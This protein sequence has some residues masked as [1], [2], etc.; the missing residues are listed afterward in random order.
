MP[1]LRLG[2]HPSNTS[3]FV[4]ERRPAPLDV[5]VTWVPTPGTATPAALRDDVIDLTGTGSTPPLT[6]LA[7]GADVV[8]LATSAPRPQHGSLVVRDDSPIRELADLAGRRV[9]LA[10]GSYQSSLLVEALDRE[11]LRWSD[12]DAVPGH[13]RAGAAAF[14][15]GE[16]D[17]WI[18]GDP[19]LADV[20]SRVLTRQ[21][22][23]TDELISNR[24]VWFARRDVV[25]GRREEVLAV[26]RA[27]HETDHRIATRPGEAAELL[28]REVEGEAGLD[29]VDAWEASL[30]RRPWGLLPVGEEF[31]A[32]QQ[33]SADLLHRDGQLPA[34]VDVAGAV[35][36]DVGR[37]VAAFSPVA[38]GA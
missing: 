30:R 26:L 23:A 28:A 7:A 33:H 19:H 2:V 4:L 18:G 10:I 21:L 6:A 24:S 27:L 12:V 1:S 20:Q 37:A 8:Y 29:S 9:G 31:V 14:E 35:D 25:E 16:L 38:V 32:E 13:G 3:L 5:A 17:A 15:S 11:G 22:V 36:A 34:A